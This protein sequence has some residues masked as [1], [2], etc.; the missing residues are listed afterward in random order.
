M[1]RVVS[2]FMAT[3]VCPVIPGA[4]LTGVTVIARS[5]VALSLVPS[6]T[7]TCAVRVPLKSCAGV[8]VLP[9]WV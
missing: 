9:L 1:V 4:S 5:K 2:S 8:M 3:V 7:A 6:L